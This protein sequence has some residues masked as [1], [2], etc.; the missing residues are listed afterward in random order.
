M[1]QRVMVHFLRD[2]PF[3]H[4]Y[5]DDVVIFSKYMEEDLRHLEKVLEKVAS[6]NLKLRILKCHFGKV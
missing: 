2:L 3:V 6:N 1:F 5:L 4:V